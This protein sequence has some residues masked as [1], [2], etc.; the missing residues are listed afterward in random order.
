MS[1]Y[2]AEVLTSLKARY[3]WEKEYIQSVSEVFKSIAPAVDE[4]PEYRHNKILEQLVE[5]DRSITFRVPW[6]DDRGMLRVNTGYRVEFNNALGPYKGGLRF[7]AGKGLGWGGSCLRPEA[8]G[9]GVVYFAREVLNV[10][11]DTIEGKTVSVS[12]F[13]N[14]AW[15]WEAGSSPCPARMGSYTIL[16]ASK[17]KKSTICSRC[18]SAVMMW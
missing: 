1:S 13:G 5:P 2:T 16:T 9:F 17:A 8:T 15:G 6:R 4:M 11:N 14:V 18:A 10:K 7:H 3:P 12:G